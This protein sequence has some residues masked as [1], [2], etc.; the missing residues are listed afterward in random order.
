MD[1]GRDD[2]PHWVSCRARCGLCPNCHTRH[3]EGPKISEQS[4]TGEWS[5]QC[6]FILTNLFLFCFSLS[7]VRPVLLPHR[8]VLFRCD[9]L[10]RWTLHFVIDDTVIGSHLCLCLHFFHSCVYT[11]CFDCC[12]HTARL[13]YGWSGLLNFTLYLTLCITNLWLHWCV[14]NLP[15]VMVVFVI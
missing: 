6:R 3:K 10:I 1:T 13:T 11:I 4:S 5:F 8:P 14:R 2:R 12:V 7:V 9:H 15:F